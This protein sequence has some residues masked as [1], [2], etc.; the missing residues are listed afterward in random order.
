[1]HPPST[2][3]CFQPSAPP[4][5]FA[6]PAYC[7]NL[8]DTIGNPPVDQWVVLAMEP[9]PTPLDICRVCTSVNTALAWVAGGMLMIEAWPAPALAAYQ[10]A[11][12]GLVMG[13][14]PAIILHSPEFAGSSWFITI[15]TIRTVCGV[16]ASLCNTVMSSQVG[17]VMGASMVCCST[18]A[19]GGGLLMVSN[20][21]GTKE[22]NLNRGLV[23]RLCVCV[24]SLWGGM[25]AVP[26]LVGIGM[27]FSD[28]WQW[29][30]PV[31]TW[32]VIPS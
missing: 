29:V 7:E 15:A 2:F 6:P 13:C 12:S 20:M 17:V 30:Q 25:V 18:L 4:L 1:M 9:D 28:I 19:I 5:P 8:Q 32:V 24:A 14:V 26:S 31:F 11:W 22:W 23:T 10:G 3:L 21:N 27:V 16:V